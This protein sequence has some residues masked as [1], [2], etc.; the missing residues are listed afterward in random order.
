MKKFFVTMLLMATTM[1]MMAVPAK[2]GVWKTLKLQD[3]TEVRAQLVGDEFGHLWVDEAGKAY[4]EQNDTQI[5]KQVEKKTI[6]ERAKARRAKVNAKR[7]QKRAFGHPTTI[8]GNK[9]AIILLV[10]FK[11]QKFNSNHNN[12]LYQRIANEAGFSEGNFKGSMADYF[13][14]QSRDKFTLDFDVV[15][16]LTVSKQA[17]YYGSNDSNDQDMHP[18]EMICEAVELAK[19]EVSDWTP[20]DWDGDGY[21]DQVYVVYAGQG[22]ADGGASSTIWPHAY[23]L[24]SAKAY[25]DGTGPVEVG[26]NLYVNSYACGSELD[27]DS[28][29][30]GIGVMCHEYSHC[31]G[32]PDF[33]D[34]DYGEKNN[35]VPGPGMGSWDLMDQGSYNGNGFQPAGY[36]SYERWFAGW[37]E[38]IELKDEDVEVRNMK[39]LQNGGEFYIIYNDKNANEYYMLENRQLDGWDASL[40]SAGML[41][42]H[43]DYDAQVW[44]N[45]APNDDTNHQRFIPVTANGKYTYSQ[46]SGYYDEAELFPYSSVNAFNKDFKTTEKIARKAAQFFTKT[47]NGTY[48]MNGSVEA[49]T[50][51]SDKTISFNYVADYAGNGGGNGGGTQGDDDDKPVVEGALFYESF[52]QCKGK[53]GNDGQWSGQVA[54]DTFTPD[55]EEWEAEKSYGANKC[56]KFGTSSIAGVATTPAFELNGTTTMTFKAGA[57]N[58]TSDL[59]TLKLSA[60]GGIIEPATVEM[61]RGA[62]TDYTVSVTGNGNVKVTFE[63]EVTGKQKGRFFLDEVLVMDNTKTAI[64]NINTHKT[65][66]NKIYTIDGRF[67]GTDPD[68]LPRGLYIINGKK[69]VK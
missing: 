41:I 45:N 46:W 43:C 30:S 22:E 44:E 17:S 18:A 64:E 37:E 11:N 58:T 19:E 67:V 13:K 32:Y 38:P 24:Y 29:I 5:Y 50:K 23:D 20:Y 31:L 66:T 57:W 34:I 25:G 27:G 10:N 63:V 59:T 21:V 16:P 3:G 60:V 40:P 65:T 39:S 33:Y 68:L 28:G 56:A 8:L 42:L 54:A 35:G 47:S 53:G 62:F 6:V 4:A 15:G 69:I 48:W 51:N 9:K 36:T 14:A 26:N 49:I 12:A 1:T 55:N 61:T 52:D 2:K 7:V